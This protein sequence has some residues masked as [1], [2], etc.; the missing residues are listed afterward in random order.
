MRRRSEREIQRRNGWREIVRKQQEGGL[1]VRAYCRQAG[2]EESA[3]YWWRREL[4]RRDRDDPQD[5]SVH[6]GAAS[7]SAARI[8]SSVAGG[9]GF[10]PVQVVADHGEARVPAIE[11]L[12]AGGC[13]LRVLPGFDWQTL[14]D[15][16]GVLEGRGC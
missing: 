8:S 15:V 7:K 6:Q 2:V 12:L 9:V 4:A 5:R 13:V 11:V 14:L 3:F 1:S 10:L 16:L